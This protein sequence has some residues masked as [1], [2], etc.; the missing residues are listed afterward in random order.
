MNEEQDYE[1]VERFYINRVDDYSCD[2]WNFTCH[3]IGWEMTGKFREG[4]VCITQNCGDPTGDGMEV[5][6]LSDFKSFKNKGERAFGYMLDV[7]DDA[8]V[9]YYAAEGQLRLKFDDGE[10]SFDELMN[11]LKTGILS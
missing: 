3:V 4:M 2:H 11:D 9:H 8:G 10:M 7:T 1:E 5:T 6:L